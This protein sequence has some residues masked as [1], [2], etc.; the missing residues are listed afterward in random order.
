MLM[1]LRS[2]HSKRMNLFLLVF[3]TVVALGIQTSAG[4]ERPSSPFKVH[5]DFDLASGKPAFV[6]YQQQFYEYLKSKNQ[7]VDKNLARVRF[8]LDAM[9]DFVGL[10]S[11]STS[12]LSKI[13]QIN[14]RK[15]DILNRLSAL[16]KE[17]FSQQ[18]NLKVGLFTIESIA[19]EFPNSLSVEEYNSNKLPRAKIVSYEL[20]EAFP[21]DFNK[22][23]FIKIKI[24]SFQPYSLNSIMIGDGYMDFTNGFQ[25]PRTTEEFKLQYLSDQGSSAL[26][27]SNSMRKGLRV[28][29]SRKW[30]GDSVED[31]YV[32]R[33]VNA[34]KQ[35]SKIQIIVSERTV[36]DC[37][38]IILDPLSGSLGS[39][40]GGCESIPTKRESIL[41]KFNNIVGETAL[42]REFN[43]YFA[44]YKESF[45]Y[46]YAASL[47][48]DY[49]DPFPANTAELSLKSENL[50]VDARSLD[51]QIQK[52]AVISSLK[53]ST[54]T[55]IKGKL[56]KKVTAVRPKC[57]SGYKVKK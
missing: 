21:D 32:L 2:I 24:K 48:T 6:E 22:A 49:S 52:N 15:L 43:Q 7:D 26:I 51:L 1:G 20:P 3:S 41:G 35:L 56:T 11:I 33:H 8:N 38:D 55:C 47:Y 12:D 39:G 46:G 45:E 36:T 9:P 50:R 40:N 17:K 18:T 37:I 29:Q 13:N 53:P 34:G 14:G 28:T 27:N 25:I 30:N 31:T 23:F 54:I 42:E 44:I 5:S 16:E 4:L 57:P 10:N 19:D